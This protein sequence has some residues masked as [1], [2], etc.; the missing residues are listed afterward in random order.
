MHYYDYNNATRNNYYANNSATSMIDIS[1]G[2]DDIQLSH[3]EVKLWSIL[4]SIAE[5]ILYHRYLRSKLSYPIRGPR[6]LQ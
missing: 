3:A 6:L 5:I 1:V 2:F 4:C